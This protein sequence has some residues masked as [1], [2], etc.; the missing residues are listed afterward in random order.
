MG[1]RLQKYMFFATYPIKRGGILP[2]K[3]IF[4]RNTPKNCLVVKWEFSARKRAL[5]DEE[6]S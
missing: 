4:L 6:T 1:F 5:V 2:E 3:C